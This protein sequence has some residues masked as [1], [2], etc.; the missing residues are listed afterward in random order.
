MQPV[1][2][3]QHPERRR[4]AHR[5]AERFGSL[6][7][8]AQHQHAVIRVGPGTGDHARP[9]RRGSGIGLADALGDLGRGR[10]ALLG[11]QAAH[12]REQ[13]VTVRLDQVHGHT[14]AQNSG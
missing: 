4:A 7:A 10:D 8:V 1:G 14:R 3:L 9:L 5:N 11:Q 12:R 2:I 13:P 6:G